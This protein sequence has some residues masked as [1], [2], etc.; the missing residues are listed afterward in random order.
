MGIEDLDKAATASVLAQNP[1]LVSMI[2]GRLGS[3]IGK[4]SGYV[5]SLPPKVRERVAGLKAIQQD[6]S[7]LEAKFQERVLELEKEFFA[8][9]TPLY[10]RRAQIINGQTEPTKAEIEAGTPDDKDED[11]DEEDDESKAKSPPAESK[12][13]ADVAGI[14]E[15]WLTAMKNQVS[16][17]ELL[18][19]RDEKCLQTLTDI[20][21]Q[22]LDRPGF[23]LIFV[24][25]E[26]D[27][28]TNK[29][30]KK[31]Y[32]YQE[33]SGYGGDFI[34]DHADGDKINW[35]PD[36]DLTVRI[37]SKKQRNKSRLRGNS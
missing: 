1:K 31:T 32:Y 18:T 8:L 22:Y 34:Y 21:M 3:L 9:Y 11:E 26:N 13:P 7:K 14:P 4:S 29:E 5:E 33:D 15:F 20:R 27:F 23:Q 17:A 37:E 19:D 16:L 2:Q 35:K 25:A 10:K 12:I 28:F 30:L 36:Q 6:H 24:F